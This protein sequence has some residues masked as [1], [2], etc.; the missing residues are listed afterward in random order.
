MNELILLLVVQV[1]KRLDLLAIDV[2]VGSQLP[3]SDYSILD[4]LQLNVS[5][6]LLALS[7]NVW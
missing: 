3:I 4:L 1:Y 2:Y 7:A 6:C 5:Q